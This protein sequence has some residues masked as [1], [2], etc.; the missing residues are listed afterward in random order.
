MWK[1]F[2]RNVPLIGVIYMVMI[3]DNNAQVDLNSDRDNPN[4]VD[5]FLEGSFIRFSLR[6]QRLS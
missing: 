5:Q 2:Y 6:K 4:K 1:H 3:S